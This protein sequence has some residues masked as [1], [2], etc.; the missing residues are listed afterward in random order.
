[1]ALF[2]FLELSITCQEISLLKNQTTAVWKWKIKSA[3]SWMTQKNLIP[4]ICLPKIILLK[5]HLKKKRNK[6]YRKNNHVPQDNH[7]F[8]I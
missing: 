8:T 1:M 6:K 3:Q 4:T 5:M 2:T 7:V